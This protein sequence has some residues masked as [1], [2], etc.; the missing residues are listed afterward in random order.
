MNRVFHF[1]GTIRVLD[2]QNIIT[3]EDFAMMIL[4]VDSSVY[5]SKRLKFVSGKVK[6]RK[7]QSNQKLC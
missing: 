7:R 1:V 3:E 4:I 5:C 2:N 6:I